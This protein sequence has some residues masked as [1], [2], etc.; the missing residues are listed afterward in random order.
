MDRLFPRVVDSRVFYME[1]HFRGLKYVCIERVLV[2]VCGALISGTSLNKVGNIA[3]S[4]LMN[5]IVHKKGNVLFFS[6]PSCTIPTFYSRY[7]AR[8]L[9]LFMRA[10]NRAKNRGG[11]DPVP[12][13]PIFFGKEDVVPISS[14]PFSA[15]KVPLSC[16]G[17]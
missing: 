7:R 15:K 10:F 12:F 14:F 1:Q 16:D 13:S 11:T 5:V 6:C 8:Y 3:L 9:P 2:R 17:I 4:G